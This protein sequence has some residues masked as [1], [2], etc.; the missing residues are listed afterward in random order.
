MSRLRTLAHAM[1]ARIEEIPDLAGSVVVFHRSN[2]ETEFEKRMA[3]TRGRCVVIRLIR[4]K[5]QTRDKVK[6]RFRGTYSVTLF[7]VPVLTQKDANN[8]DAL[9][10]LI[11]GKL[12]GWWPAAVPSNGSIWLDCDSITYPE[13]TEY[14]VSVLTVETP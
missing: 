14:D 5:N 11:V 4:G 3:K 9:M 1:K 10:E 2:V 13:D 6:P 8:S 12:H 7:T